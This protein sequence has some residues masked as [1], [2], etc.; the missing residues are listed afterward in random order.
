LCRQAGLNRY[1]GLAFRCHPS[2]AKSCFDEIEQLYK[3]DDYITKL[4]KSIN[5]STTVC[6]L[7]EQLPN[8]L[9]FQ[10]CHSLL[11]FYINLIFQEL[12]LTVDNSRSFSKFLEFLFFQGAREPNTFSRPI[13]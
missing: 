4:P 12:L 9:T 13:Y 1:P 10:V 5:G 6:I 8:I 2:I 11:A 3:G 7:K